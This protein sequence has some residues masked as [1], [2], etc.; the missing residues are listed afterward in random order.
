M[1]EVEDK[2]I[3]IKVFKTSRFCAGVGPELRGP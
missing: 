1:V 3:N 2:D